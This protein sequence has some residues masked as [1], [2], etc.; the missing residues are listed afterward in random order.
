[1][2]YQQIEKVSADPPV[3]FPC[4]AWECGPDA[5]RTVWGSHAEDESECMLPRRRGAGSPAPHPGPGDAKPPL[6]ISTQIMGTR[7][8][9]DFF[10]LLSV[11]EI[12]WY[13]KQKLFLRE[14]IMK[15]FKCCIVAL[16][17]MMGLC[18]PLLARLPRTRRNLLRL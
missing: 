16:S 12:I 1:M 18:F 2:K 10:D 3:S 17:F 5:S 11:S 13:Y 6:R 8:C 14:G 4:P 7:P 15:L 9:R